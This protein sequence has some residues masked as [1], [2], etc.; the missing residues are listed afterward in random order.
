[1]TRLQSPA[2]TLFN[3][4]TEYAHYSVF[5]KTFRLGSAKTIY[6]NLK[7]VMKNKLLLALLLSSAIASTSCKKTENTTE[8]AAQTIVVEQNYIPFRTEQ[9]L[10]IPYMLKTWEYLKQ[11]L[12]LERIVVFDND[13]KA[14]LMTIEK[15]DIPFIWKAPLP[16]ST[17]FNVTKIDHY[18]LSI[19]LPIPL[20]QSVPS[21]IGH[22]FIFR[23][24]LKNLDVTMSGGYFQPLKS[25]SPRLISPPHRG[26]YYVL[27]NQSTCGY[28]FWYAAFVEGQ[29]YTSE[30]FAFDS[31]QSDS[32]MADTYSGDPKKNESYF[33]YGDTIY[34]VA[35]GMVVHLQDGRAE[36]QGN[37]HN[38]PLNKAD[39][40]CGN[41]LILDI[42]GGAW[43][44]FAHIKPGSFLVSE[45]D[46]ITEGQ[47]IALVGNSGN[48]TEPHLHF[49][50]QNTI[51]YFFSGGLPFAFKKF[52][53]VG[54]VGIGPI[55]PIEV[56]NATGENYD[57][58]N[59]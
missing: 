54:Q 59:F 21:N 24:T 10:R 50:L 23:D 1:M 57:F 38:V 49:Q 30:K 58:M 40:Y 9:Y 33:I 46:Q 14:D 18:Y 51:D 44:S 42:G 25:E 56:I 41:Y 53:K 17:E 2:R 3:Y 28:H 36:N 12:R 4:Q 37:S 31:N 43:A 35:S 47:P 7:I 15:A 34:A 32:T 27:I 52:T 45:G 29:V 8:P 26:R 19:Q 20:A 39:D 13:S 11:G 55:Q 6:R 48:S 5:L 22:R 16:V